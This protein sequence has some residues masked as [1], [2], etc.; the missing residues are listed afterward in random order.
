MTLSTALFIEHRKRLR[1][2]PATTSLLS[3]KSN[4][5]SIK[6]RME[7]AFE[8]TKAVKNLSKTSLMELPIL[9]TAQTYACIFAFDSPLTLEK[10]AE[11]YHEGIIK[12]GLGRHVDVVLVLDKGVITLSAQVP[13]FG[14]SW[15]PLTYQGAGG[16]YGEG[17]HIAVGATP[18]KDDSLD[19]FL[20]LLLAQLMHFRGLM[21]HPGFNWAQQGVTVASFMTYVTSVTH[22]KDPVVRHAKLQQYAAQIRKEFG[23][24]PA[25]DTSGGGEAPREAPPAADTPSVIPLPPPTKI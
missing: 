18:M 15:S 14:A 24:T 19:M 3:W 23:A 16:G 7:E 10:L 12:H 6:K 4:L 2:F 11:H 22:E 9:Q 8:N 20:R 1:L 21:A 5:N 13:E 17:S 25:P